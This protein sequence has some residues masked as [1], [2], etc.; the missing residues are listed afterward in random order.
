LKG[1]TLKL[2]LVASVAFVLF[3]I[4]LRSLVPETVTPS[5]TLLSLPLILLVII[6]V[7]DLSYRA[8]APSK[9]PA[10]T[11]A[12][13]VQAKYVQYLSRQIEVGSI[14]SEAYFD[15]IL[16]ARLRDILIEKA[17]LETGIEKENLKH[18]LANPTKGPGLI[19]DRALYELLYSSTAPKGPARI[20]MLREA[21]DR[22]EAWNP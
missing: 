8:T 9:V 6:L 5:V 16:R 14:G 13:R 10:R 21:V 15:T 2:L 3:L 11:R 18:Q 1:S 4:F 22:I 20:R 19:K 17:S 7:N 12:R